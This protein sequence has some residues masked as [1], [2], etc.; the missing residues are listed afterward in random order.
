MQDA[1]ARQAAYYAATA[2]VYNSMHVDDDDDEHECA[3]RI[4]SAAIPAIGA[5]SVLDVGTG[6]GR[7]LIRLR[8]DNPDLAVHG[9]D[10]V[11]ELLAQ[12][13]LPSTMITV[14]SGDRLPFAA[15]SF[16]VVCSFGVLHHVPNSREVIE[17]MK[18]VARE[19]V[20]ISD[21]NRFGMGS[22][23]TRLLKLVLYRAGLWNLIV[24]I[25]SRGRGYFVSEGDGV[26][27][28]YSVFYDLP[29]FNGWTVQL[30]STSKDQHD[31]SWLMPLLTDSHLLVVAYA[32][33][34]HGR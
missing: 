15:D 5:R 8:A 13:G 34:K 29:A 20:F 25:R 16:D 19:A 14:G 27:Y 31:G 22:R 12:T 18:R 7:A 24:K 10:P 9:I 2:D 1:R 23:K 6:T 33:G 32:K 28:S 3:L 21:V 30:I 11:P 17:E 4:L 26:S